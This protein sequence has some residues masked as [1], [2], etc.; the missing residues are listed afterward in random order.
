MW[1][2]R[3]WKVTAERVIRGGVAGISAVW[4]A[5]DVVF[6]VTNVNSWG[7]IGSAF[8]GGAFSALVLSLG[9]NAVSGNGPA[10]TE[11][12]QIIPPQP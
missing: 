5:G 2:K 11:N 1:T 9:G 3:F 8:A 12:E 6:D 10:F 7:D 4:L